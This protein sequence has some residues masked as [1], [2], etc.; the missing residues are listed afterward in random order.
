M[1]NLAFCGVDTVALNYIDEH[2][3]VWTKGKENAAV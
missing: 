3:H 2:S 1:E